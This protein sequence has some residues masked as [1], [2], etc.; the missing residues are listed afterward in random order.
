MASLGRLPCC[1]NRHTSLPRAHNGYG[2]EIHRVSVISDGLSI[3]DFLIFRQPE[4]FGLSFLLPI[5]WITKGVCGGSR[6]FV[7][8]GVNS[9]KL[10]FDEH[11][12]VVVQDGKPVY[13]HDDGKEIPFDAQAAMQKIT[14]L[15][16]EAK[17][18]REAKET[19]E[20]K[21]KAFDGIEDAQTA[22]KALATVKNLDDKKLIDA[23][24]AERVKSEAIKVYEE[25]LAA[26][27]SEKAKIQSQFQNELIGGN[28]ARSKVIAEKLAI[29][30]DMAQA[31][32]G[33]HFT[34]SEDGKMIAKD[35]NGHEIYSRIHAGEKATFDVGNFD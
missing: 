1:D 6:F 30:V 15:N 17:Q 34:I 35:A 3:A 33:K 9:M 24:E 18:H 21:L 27:E 12:H 31:F 14:S 11:H 28:F 13:V 25:K 10:K 29:P 22:L 2:G 5:R 4:T 16:A 20:A 7:F 8:C 32:F 19:A 23:G 26:L